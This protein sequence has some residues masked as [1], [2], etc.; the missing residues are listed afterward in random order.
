MNPER[1][2]KVL[3]QSFFFGKVFISFPENGIL[4]FNYTVVLYLKLSKRE[5]EAKYEE[6]N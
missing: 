5:R 3:W 4:T 1:L 2:P 6:Y